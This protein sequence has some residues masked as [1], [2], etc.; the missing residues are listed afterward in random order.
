MGI[1]PNLNIIVLIF[2]FLST[3]TLS[4]L[5]N[6]NTDKN[7]VITMS[8]GSRSIYKVINAIQQPEGVGA[9]VRRS[10]GIMS[11]RK[12]NPFLLFD[13]FASSGVDGFPEHPHR[14]QETITY[15]MN[16]GIAH[17]DFTGSKGILYKGDL[18]FMTA[19][20]GIV[21][22]EMPIPSEDGSPSVGM[23]LWVDLPEP[24]KDSAP[25]YRDLRAW[26]IPEVHEQDD[27]LVVKVISGKSY[28]VESL[29]DL[30]Y[31]PVNYYHYIMK[32]GS[33]FKQDFEPDYNVFL[34]VLKGNSLVL[35][36]TNE[37]VKQ[38]QNVLFNTD[39]GFVGGE[40]SADSNDEVEFIL[41]GGKQLNQNVV[42]YGPFVAT[43]QE[44]IQQAFL[45]YNYAR[46]GFDN[47]KNWRTLISNGVTK[48][49]IN[50]PLQGSLE[51]REELKKAY[52]ENL[53]NQKVP[54][55]D[56]L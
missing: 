18:Q 46:N 45:D 47:I 41:V 40:V 51:H 11:N 29:K 34:Y 50:G 2:L 30:A 36:G 28:G 26:E 17:E 16:G 10:I 52:L 25:R 42:Q 12:F 5:F 38:Y 4:S 8:G 53:K 31:T 3:L 1:I 39:G 35:T 33:N 48:E 44:K 21:H 15:V 43:S 54:A 9:T 23:Q 55:K 13:H 14:G 24:L 19:G 32:P 37:K 49:M 56:E 27:K 6:S 7:K 22:S 20:K